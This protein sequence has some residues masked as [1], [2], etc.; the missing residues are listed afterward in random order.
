M[1]RI[2][3]AV[4]ISL[5]LGSY[6]QR[7]QVQSAYSY[8]KYEQLDKAKESIDIAVTNENTMN[9]D[10]AWYYRGLIY[11][12]L[13]K[14]EKFGNLSSDP[15]NEAL[16]SYNKAL[17]LNPKFEYADDITEKKKIL[18][19]QFA[20]MG[21]VNYN[22]K[23]FAGALSAYEGVVAIMPNDTSSYF[24]AALCAERAG[25]VAKAKQ[26][27]TKLDEMQYKDAKMYHSYAQLYLT[28]GDTTKALEILS[29]GLSRFPEEKSILITQTNIYIS[30]GKTAEAL[31]A[32]NMAIEKDSTNA[33]LYFAKGTLVEKTEKS[34][35]AAIAAYKKAIELKADYFDAYYNL[36]ALYF[37]DAAHL[38]NE[39]NS[40]KDNNQYAKAKVVFEAKFK[41]AKPY[42]E[43]AWELNPKDQS[44][45]ISLKQLYATINDTVNYAK[46]KAALDAETK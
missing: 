8:L 34:K 19:Q 40:I 3:T 12:A 9:Y 36:G 45:M 30:S 22:L 16:R 46:V 26:F 20:D 27:Y 41:E 29:R 31:N 1:K 38:A 42:L 39:A 35:D 43:K 17:E 24:N 21:Y 14:N 33:N 13:Y 7:A 44:T 23:N 28:E 37:N 5:A 2:L 25:N 32:I 11:Q 6:A 15:L 10:K 18:A 4:F